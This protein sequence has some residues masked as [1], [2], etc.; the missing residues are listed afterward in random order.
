MEVKKIILILSLC[1]IFTVIGESS[2]VS[3]SNIP[4]DS[5]DN[6]VSVPLSNTSIV[7][8]EKL[9]LKKQRKV[10]RPTTTWS[11]IKDLFM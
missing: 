10:I 3:G 7:S 4:K 5:I 2:K 11:K 6:K 8:E 9:S 1:L